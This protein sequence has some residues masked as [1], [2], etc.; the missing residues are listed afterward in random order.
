MFKQNLKSNS[1]ELIRI[2]N[3][4]RD[5]TKQLEKNKGNEQKVSKSK[6]MICI[7]YIWL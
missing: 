6:Y 5:L 1:E 2:Q 4:N 7:H 3:I